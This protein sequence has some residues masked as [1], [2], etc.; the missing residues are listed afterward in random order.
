MSVTEYCH[1]LKSLAD[2][3][4]GLDAPVSETE[5]VMQ[6]LRQLPSSYNSIKDI[7]TNTIPF[8]MFVNARNMLLLDKSRDEYSEPRI[9][10]MLDATISL[11]H[12][13]HQNNN[14]K[15]KN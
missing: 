14:G 9:E 5:L 7:I 13:T 10:P 1:T 8:P 15:G 2:S 4:A 6:I 3:L 12:T 11:Y